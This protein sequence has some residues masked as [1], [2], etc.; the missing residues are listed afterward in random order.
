MVK[1]IHHQ[2]ADKAFLKEAYVEA[3]IDL[4]QLIIHK[5]L[6][7]FSHLNFTRLK[8]NQVR[9]KAVSILS[10]LTALSLPAK[11]LKNSSSCLTSFK[12]NHQ[13]QKKNI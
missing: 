8:K 7:P 11:K 13:S 12:F 1:T 10:K 5:S 9:N 6:L 2:R 4:L 3:Y